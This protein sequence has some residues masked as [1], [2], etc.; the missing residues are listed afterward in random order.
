MHIYINTHKHARVPPQAEAERI[1][2]VIGEVVPI[3]VD[4][5][6]LVAVAE[7]AASKNVFLSLIGRETQKT[8]N[9]INI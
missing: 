5:F 6:P 2:L 9:E 3:E 7:I 8:M 4:F 1:G